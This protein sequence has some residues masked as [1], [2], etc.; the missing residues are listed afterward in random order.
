[1]RQSKFVFE[2]SGVGLNF[3]G[4]EGEL[5]VRHRIEEC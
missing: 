2:E 5:E 3:L 1:M 4:G